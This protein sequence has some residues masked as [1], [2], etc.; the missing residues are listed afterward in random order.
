MI[1]YVLYTSERVSIISSLILVLAVAY[2]IYVIKSNLILT[3]ANKLLISQNEI[4]HFYFM[5]C[6][7]TT[8]FSVTHKLILKSQIGLV[9][10]RELNLG[11]LWQRY[12]DFDGGCTLNVTATRNYYFE[13]IIENICS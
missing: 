3:S 5:T 13:K 12:L 1:L 2:N 8:C 10:F 9:A 11:L 7:R 4:S 6:I